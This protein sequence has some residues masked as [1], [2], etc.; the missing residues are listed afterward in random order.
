M[1]SFDG[2]LVY[3]LQNEAELEFDETADDAFDINYNSNLNHFT[4]SRP[5]SNFVIR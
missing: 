4:S 1:F 5:Q 3:S 2:S